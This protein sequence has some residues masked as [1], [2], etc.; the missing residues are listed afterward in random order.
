MRQSNIS[1]IVYS[2]RRE[3]KGA[4]P[5][6][7]STWLLVGAMLSICSLAI[8]TSS[9]GDGRPATE[10][11]RQ[12]AAASEDMDTTG[13]GDKIQQ[14]KNLL[15]PAVVGSWGHTLEAWMNGY[16]MGAGQ[17]ADLDAHAEAMGDFYNF[18]VV[19]TKNNATL[20]PTLSEGVWE[21]GVL[22]A[23]CLPGAATDC[24]PGARTIS[25][26]FKCEFLKKKPQLAAVTCHNVELLG[27]NA[28]G[29]FASNQGLY[30]FLLHADSNGNFI[31][32]AMGNRRP[33]TVYARFTFVYKKLPFTGSLWTPGNTTIIQHHSSLE[34]ER[35]PRTPA[36]KEQDIKNL[37]TKWGEELKKWPYGPLQPHAMIDDHANAMRALYTADARLLPTVSPGVWTNEAAFNPNCA[38][39]T[40]A[41]YFGC[42]FLP[43]QPELMVVGS[44]FVVFSPDRKLAANHGTYIFKLNATNEQVPAR[45]TFVYKK[46]NLDDWSDAKIVMHHSSP[47][48]CTGDTDHNGVVNFA[49]VTLL[50]SSWV[51]NLGACPP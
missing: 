48:P 33:Q 20:L 1:S 6:W 13:L 9:A 35:A 37:L 4:I 29:E 10:N 30:T 51:Q 47:V 24:P 19:P 34:P 5:I 23:N 44:Q 46:G 7:L 22:A 3:A 32:D 25:T 14:I 49:D 38:N 40:I 43:K 12:A 18:A 8:S 2:G 41:N 11:Q 27:A 28:N 26:Y 15:E 17:F 31:V 50:L 36:E 21:S 16:G 39:K 42:T 45:F